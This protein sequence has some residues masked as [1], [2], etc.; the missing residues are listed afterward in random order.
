MLTND[1]IINN[2]PINNFQNSILL[3]HILAYRDTTTAYRL[4]SLV[5]DSADDPAYSIFFNVLVT[6]RKYQTETN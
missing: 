6:A 3:H 2:L 1:Q 5:R 4:K